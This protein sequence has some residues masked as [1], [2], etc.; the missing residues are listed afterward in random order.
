MA[1]ARSLRS[2]FVDTER[3][4]EMYGPEVAMYF[5]WM[6]HLLRWLLIPGVLALVCYA[7]NTTVYTIERSPAA[8]YFSLLMSVWGVVYVVDWRR[9]CRGL[10]IKWG[11][12]ILEQDPE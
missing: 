4:R 5:A 8:A 7:A 6:N 12:F 1:G 11:D 9:H 10:N 2:I 3:V